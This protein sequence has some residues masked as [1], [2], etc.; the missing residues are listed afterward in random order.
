LKAEGFID[1]I[2]EWWSSFNF[3]GRPDYILACK[4]RALKSK[5]KEWKERGRGKL[6]HS[7]E[8]TVGTDG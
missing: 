6:D 2:R 7:E 3:T 8:E 1:T 4:L 5:L